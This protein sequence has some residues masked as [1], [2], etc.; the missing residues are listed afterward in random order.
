MEWVVG[1]FT[2]SEARQKW[3]TV[4]LDLQ[5]VPLQAFLSVSAESAS[6]ICLPIKVIVYAVAFTGELPKFMIPVE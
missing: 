3:Q 6:A 4:V 5:K 2:K 1:N